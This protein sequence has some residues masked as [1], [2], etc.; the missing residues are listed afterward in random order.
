MYLY[1]QET[2]LSHP[3]SS[4]TFSVEKELEPQLGISL[5]KLTSRSLCAQWSCQ[6]LIAPC[7]ALFAVV[8]IS[9]GTFPV[10]R[11]GTPRPAGWM[12]LTG[13]SACRNPGL[14]SYPRDPNPIA[15][16]PPDSQSHS[17]LVSNSSLFPALPSRLCRLRW[18][19]AHHFGLHSIGTDTP[20]THTCALFP[21][22]VALRS[23]FS[24]VL[25]PAVGALVQPASQPASQCGNL[26]GLRGATR[27]NAPPAAHCGPCLAC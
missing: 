17:R 13:P 9:A 12:P 24:P 23:F 16:F 27:Q 25:Q 6:L 10:R 7:Q 8:L 26:R 14:S 1:L 2:G 18:K 4:Q 19:Q 21:A 22:S 3:D 20:Q 15:H 5:A 11:W